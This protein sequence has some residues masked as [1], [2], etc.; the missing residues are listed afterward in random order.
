[1]KILGGEND[2]LNIIFDMGNVI[3]RYDPEYFIMKEGITAKD[4]KNLLMRTIFRSKEWP[5]L[6]GGII[7]ESELE[8][9][10][11]KRLPERL[12][13]TAHR[14]IFHWDEH[15]DPIPG[16]FEL[17][18]DLNKNGSRLFLL[19]NA[20]VRQPEYWRRMAVSEYFDGAVV[21]GP[22]KHMKPKPE[23]YNILL[24]R[25]ELRACDCVFI[26]DVQANVTGA[27]NVGMKG[28]LFS[29]DTGDLRVKLKET[30][31]GNL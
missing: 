1:M 18:R 13:H 12:Y 28:I 31:I 25:Y 19:S 15:A 27:V 6:D 10:V 8:E 4:D 9:T 5:M 21:S 20:S 17:I 14:L 24:D 29:G 7:D 11:L 30:G 3:I 22:E 2:M 23:I 26:D 16:M